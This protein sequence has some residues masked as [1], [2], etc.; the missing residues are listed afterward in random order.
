MPAS[1]PA[2][3]TVSSFYWNEHTPRSMSATPSPAGGGLAAHASPTKVGV[4]LIVVSG[5]MGGTPDPEIA[6]NSVPLC[7]PDGI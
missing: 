7:G 4:P 2:A 5:S 1:Y 3:L 6:V